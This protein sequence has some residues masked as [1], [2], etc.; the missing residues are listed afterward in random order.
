LNPGDSQPFKVFD[1]HQSLVGCQIINYRVNTDEKW[2]VLVGISA[3]V[4]FFPFFPFFPV[5]FLSSCALLKEER[6]EKVKKKRD[7]SQP[8][9]SCLNEKIK[10]RKGCRCDPALLQG[11]LCF[12]AHR[13]SRCG[14]RRLQDGWLCLAIQALCLLCEER[15]WCQGLRSLLSSPS[16]PSLSIFLQ[17]IEKKNTLI[18]SSLLC[19]LAS[20]Y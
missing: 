20:R 19:C 6:E 9:L 18:F 11:P 1:R 2:M 7:R 10:A 16:F 14:F 13:G 8:F 15:H 3:Q 5:F 4:S 17:Q 12:S